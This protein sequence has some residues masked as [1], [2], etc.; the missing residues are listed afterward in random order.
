MIFSRR[1]RTTSST[2]RGRLITFNGVVVTERSV[3]TG[4]LL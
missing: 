4:A 3:P 2:N 1:T